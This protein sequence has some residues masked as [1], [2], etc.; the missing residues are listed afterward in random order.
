MGNIGGQLA[1]SAALLGA[2]LC[3]LGRCDAPP[4]PIASRR[5]V[6]AGGMM[7]LGQER[8]EMSPRRKKVAE[9]VKMCEGKSL[10]E[11]QEIFRTAAY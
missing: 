7:R 3:H 2:I 5:G 8:S 1:L 11:K 4:R 10:E 9:L 6:R